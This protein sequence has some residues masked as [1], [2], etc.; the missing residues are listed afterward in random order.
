MRTK[1][2]RK[3]IVSGGSRSAIESQNRSAAALVPD[4]GVP[5]TDEPAAPANPISRLAA[6]HRK[7]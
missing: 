3:L 5:A 2:C 7:L 6:R 1:R 4:D